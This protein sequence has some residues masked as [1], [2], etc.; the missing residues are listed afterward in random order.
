MVA[1]LIYVPVV[2]GI[3]TVLVVC[4]L[5]SVP[6]GVRVNLCPSGVRVNLSPSGVWVK[7]VPLYHIIVQGSLDRCVDGETA[8]L[9]LSGAQETG[10]TGPSSSAG[11]PLQVRS[12][13][14]GDSDSLI[15]VSP[16][17]MQAQ[18]LHCVG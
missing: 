18:Q 15:Q 8:K 10:I 9:V 16:V 6:S 5:I 11:L 2:P 1:G 4:G 3:M 7:G 14:A 12:L 13:Q 17:S